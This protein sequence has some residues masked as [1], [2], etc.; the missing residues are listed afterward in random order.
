M[1]TIFKTAIATTVVATSMAIANPANAL[2]FNFSYTFESGD[3]LSG[4]LE[5]DIFEEEEDVVI[6]SE[7]TSSFFNG[8]SLGSKEVVNFFPE[9]EIGLAAIFAGFEPFTPVVSFSGSFMDIFACDSFVLDE[10]GFPLPGDDECETGFASFAFE[11]GGFIAGEGFGEEF[12]PE[13]WSLTHATAVP[14]PAAVL[15]I[16]TGLFGAASKRKQDEA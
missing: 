14:T 11:E 4:V 2:T 12:N 9:T 10:E 5:G 8:T 3:T 1:K 13:S 7:I 15:P 6:V 16:L